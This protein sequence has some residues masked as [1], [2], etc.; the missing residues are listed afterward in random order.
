MINRVSGR[1]RRYG[2]CY[3]FVV[4]AV[5]VVVVVFPFMEQ[6]RSANDAMV[7]EERAAAKPWQFY[8]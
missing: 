5:V 3:C 6:F 8:E 7:G 1:G 4:I 2:L